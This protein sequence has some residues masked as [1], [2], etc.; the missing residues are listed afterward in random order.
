MPTCLLRMKGASGR[1]AAIFRMARNRYLHI[2][3]TYCTYYH[4]FDDL[5]IQSPIFATQ[6]RNC[7][8]INFRFDHPSPQL[9]EAGFDVPES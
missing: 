1:E 4:W 3:I 7:D 8:T 9:S 6:S 2:Q 5:P